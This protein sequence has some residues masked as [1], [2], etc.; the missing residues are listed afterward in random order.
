[1]F[2]N[3]L[4]KILVLTGIT[5]R[6]KAILSKDPAAAT[7]AA[8][9]SLNEVAMMPPINGP[10][11]IPTPYEIPSLPRAPARATE[12]NKLISNFRFVLGIRK[13]LF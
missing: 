4:L 8:D 11:I 3:F 6:T 5:A 7:L 9:C 12:N 2:S 13:S 10:A 1:M